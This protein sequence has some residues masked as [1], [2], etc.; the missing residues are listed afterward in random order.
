MIKNHNT[1]L[2]MVSAIEDHYKTVSHAKLHLTQ[3]PWKREW[4]LVIDFT[5]PPFTN[6]P[7]QTVPPR[8]HLVTSQ[9]EPSGA[10]VLVDAL[11][12]NNTAYTITLSIV[13]VL[14]NVLTT[15]NTKAMDKTLN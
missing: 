14:R 1:L 8:D 5:S 11:W 13:V 9:W 15:E 3:V 12:T 7:K 2:L 4:P 10:A 6:F